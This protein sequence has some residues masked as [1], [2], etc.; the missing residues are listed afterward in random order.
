MTATTRAFCTRLKRFTSELCAWAHKEA[1]KKVKPS[2]K[3]V[4]RKGSGR[5]IKRSTKIAGKS[6]RSVG[7]KVKNQVKMK[8]SKDRP[9]R[10]EDEYVRLFTVPDTPHECFYSEEYDLR[11]PS[12]LKYVP[13]TTEPNAEV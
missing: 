1:G 12:A 4:M 6:S 5:G 11:Q 9:A 3:S 8:S 2:N 10:I 13:S 7:V